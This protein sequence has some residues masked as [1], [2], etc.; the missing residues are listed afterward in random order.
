MYEEAKLLDLPSNCQ[1]QLRH[2]E[3]INAQ[4]GG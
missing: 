2:F 3:R 4:L 1:L